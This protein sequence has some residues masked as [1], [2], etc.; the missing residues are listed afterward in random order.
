MKSVI[1]GM[2]GLTDAITVFI[3]SKCREFEV[4]AEEIATGVIERCVRENRPLTDVANDLIKTIFDKTIEKHGEGLERD[5]F[6][7]VID[8][9]RSNLLYDGY[10]M[11]FKSS[12]DDARHRIQVA[13][14]WKRLKAAPREFKLTAADKKMLLDGGCLEEDLEW[15]EIECNVC[16]YTVETKNTTKSISREEAI[17]LLGRKKYLWGVER[18]CFHCSAVQDVNKNKNVCFE[19]G[20]P[21]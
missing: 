5:K 19:S 6:T 14:E 16:H 3:E 7:M 12:F 18:A 20:S 2:F 21:Q 9:V 4:D 11:I 8:G 15:I 10:G 17:R 1:Y 13:E